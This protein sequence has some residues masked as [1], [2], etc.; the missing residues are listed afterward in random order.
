MRIIVL[1]GAYGNKMSPESSC[2]DKYLQR[3]KTIATIEVICPKAHGNTASYNG[4]QVFQISNFWNS[5]RV[6]CQKRIDNRNSVLFWQLLLLIVRIHG[7]IL[8]Y[9]RFPTRN[10]WLKKGY[11]KKLYDISSDNPID[12]LISVGG[13]PCAHWAALLY[14]QNHDK[15]RWITYTL[16]PFTINIDVYKNVLFKRHKRKR[17]HVMEQNFWR[18]ADWVIF[19]EELYEPMKQEFGDINNNFQCFPYVLDKIYTNN[20]VVLKA[21]TKQLVAVYAGALYLH[22]RN[23]QRALEVLSQVDGLKFELYTSGE[24]APMILTYSGLNVVLKNMLPR[25]DYL[26]LIN[27]YADILVNISNSTNL[28]APSKF[29]ELLSTGLPIIN[30]YTIKNDIGFVSAEQI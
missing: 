23:P 15:I 28:M 25:D 3:L 11:L 12:A 20:S 16:D 30:F 29:L 2:I 27:N 22:I 1:T 6:L 13:L 4:I 10:A 14:K 5:L 7:A 26:Y 9:F 8:S 24:C 17:N 19:T 18:T 21:D